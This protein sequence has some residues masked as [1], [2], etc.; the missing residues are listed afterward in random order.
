MN[1]NKRFFKKPEVE[2]EGE[3]LSNSF[4]KKKLIIILFF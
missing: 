1:K 4:L 2:A 3:E